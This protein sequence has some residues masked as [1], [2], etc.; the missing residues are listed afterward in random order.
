MAKRDYYE[1]LGVDKNSSEEEIKKAYKKLAMKFHPDKNPGDKD[2]EEK[3]KELGEAY[4]ILSDQQKR[5]QFDRFGHASPGSGGMGGG[6]SMDIDPFEIFRSFMGGFG[7]FGGFGDFGFG[8]SSRTQKVAGRELQLK[9]SLSLEEISDGVTKKLKIKRLDKCDNCDGSGAKPGT[10]LIQCPACNGAGEIRRSAMGGI[11][12]Q[13]YACDRCRGSGK[14]IKDP[15][16][17]CKGDGRLRGE[18]TISVNIPAGVNHGNY[19]YLRGQGNAGPNDGPR[20]D[21]KAVIEESEHEYF[22]RDEDDIIYH[23]QISFP[24][25]ALGDSVEVPTLGGRARLTVPQGTQSGKVFRMRGRGIKHLNGYGSGDQLVVVQIFTPTKVNQDEKE[26][27][28]KLSDS[29]NMKPR[30]NDKG[31]FKKVRDAFF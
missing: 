22:I 25:A 18:T 3:F 12:T 23:L 14:I 9:L 7:G 21:I 17:R 31:F 6:A 11:F 2:A 28:Q 1:V 26:L 5:A 30:P 27:L 24:Q 8:Q 15:C 10:S 16:P 19:I 20:G 29:E 4:A 13:M